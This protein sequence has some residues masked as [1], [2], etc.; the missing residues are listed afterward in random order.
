MSPSMVSRALSGGIV[1]EEKRQQV[2]ALAEKYQY[3]PN[4]FASRLS[5]RPVKI[6]VF[7][8]TKYI[9]GSELLRKGIQM[10]HSELSDYKIEL[11]MIVKNEPELDFEEV[12][13]ALDS[14]RGY[15]G[16]IVSGLN[17]DKF[18][19]TL[20]RLTESMPNLVMLQQAN[21]KVNYLF[22]SKHDEKTASG[23]ACDFFCSCFKNSGS[24]NVL[25]FTGSLDSDV[26]R[27]AKLAF[28]STCAQ[29][30]IHVLDVVD[31]R[32]D[33]DVL[34]QQ[35]P[36]VFGKYAD[37]INGCYI[38]SGISIS[39]CDYIRKYRPDVRLV[40][41]D[42]YD[43]LNT[44]IHNGTVDATLYQNLSRQGYVAF[45]GLVEHIIEHKPLDKVIYTNVQLVTKTGL[46]VL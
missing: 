5:M 11:D 19:Q 18:T 26:H 20:N 46:S 4:R 12:C 7:I 37:Q 17:A 30:G 27:N 13:R 1:E 23:I 9:S 44:Y 22:A 43:K 29:R 41:F 42:V 32:D 15:D 31:M 40:T 10:A 39:L 8:C 25:L 21:E 34:R 6:G 35:L 3:M 36:I 38:T 14:F 33:E 2:F 24:R 45:R 28:L 16:V